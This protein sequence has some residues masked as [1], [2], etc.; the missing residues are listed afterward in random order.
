MTIKPHRN[1]DVSADVIAECTDNLSKLAYGELWNVVVPS[2][3]T[4][5]KENF[6][7]ASEYHTADPLTDYWNLLTEQAQH[8]INEALENQA[9]EWGDDP[10]LE[11]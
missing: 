3:K 11:D 7:S 5:N 6:G 9:Q 2:M 1:A 8:D 4:L 10:W